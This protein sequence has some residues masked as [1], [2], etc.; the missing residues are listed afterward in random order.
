MVRTCNWQALSSKI[1]ERSFLG[2]IRS[3]SVFC[4]PMVNED[5]KLTCNWNCRESMRTS[6]LLTLEPFRLFRGE[7][8]LDDTEEHLEIVAGLS[9]SNV[10]ECWDDLLDPAIDGTEAWCFKALVGRHWTSKL[11][12]EPLP[13]KSC[14]TCWCDFPLKWKKN[15]LIMA[16]SDIITHHAN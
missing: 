13:L 5:K 3:L 11:G 10:T 2:L 12:W 7:N 8:A 6:V 9:F 16:L 14:T 4:H 15:Y 1:L